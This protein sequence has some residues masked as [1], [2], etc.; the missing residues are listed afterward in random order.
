MARL[1]GG[2][3]L[4]EVYIDEPGAEAREGKT[5]GRGQGARG[6]DR[7][8]HMGEVEERFCQST[9]ISGATGKT[10]NFIDVSAGFSELRQQAFEA[11]GSQ[12]SF[13]GVGRKDQ[14]PFGTAHSPEDP[15]K[16]GEVGQFQIDG[17]SKGEK[18][19][20]EENPLTG[21]PVKGATL[22]PSPESKQNRELFFSHGFLDFFR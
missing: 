4:I 13:Q 22:F 12:F 8:P 11:E 19:E 17:V 18:S 3:G 6:K 5:G 10:H 1:A 21:A 9:Q 7:Q 14:I 20:E 15:A 16:A 2:R